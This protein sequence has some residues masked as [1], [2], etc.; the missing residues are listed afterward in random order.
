MRDHVLQNYREQ[1]LLLLRNYVMAEEK[2]LDSYQTILN[3]GTAYMDSMEQNGASVSEIRAGLYPYLDGFYDL[4]SADGLRSYGIVDGQVISNDEEYE[5]FN[6]G[7]YQYADTDWYQ[8]ALAAQGSIYISSAYEDY[9]TGQV[10]VTM[11]QK[12]AHSDSV[13]AFDILFS[14]YRSGDN[15]LD[16]PEEGAY[17]LCDTYGTVMYYQNSAFDDPDE[18][19]AF[20][21][22][23]FA[24]IGDVYTE[25]FQYNYYDSQGVEQGMYTIVLDNGW[26]ILFTVPK[27]NVM[28]GLQSF[29]LS[30]LVVFA[31]GLAL[32]AHLGFRDFRRSRANRRLMDERQSM[33]KTAHI[34]HKAMRSTLLT[35]REV[36]YL[37][38][39]DGTYQ[40]V[41]PEQ[42]DRPMEG[43][44]Q[45]GIARLFDTGILR[46]DNMESVQ[47]FLSPENIRTALGTQECMETRCQHRDR[48]GAWESCVLTLTVAERVDGVPVGATMAIRSIENALRQEEAQRELLTL[49]AQQAEAANHAKSDFLSNMSHDIRTPMNAILGMT[50][51]AAM[52]VNE[53]D[54]V[55]DALNKIT[56]SGKHLLG[57]INSVLDMSK[58]ES[59]KISLNEE[60]FSLADS[61][62]SLLT[63]VHA[64]IEAKQLKLLVKTEVEHERVIGDDQ[65][66][67]QILINIMSNAIKFTP[68]GG[69]IT[70]TVREK[71]SDVTGRGCYEFV[72]EDT[73]IGMSP[74][75]VERIFEPFSRATDSRTSRIEGTGLGMSIAVNVA[76]MMGG[77]IQVESE[78]GKGSCFTVMVY[79]KLDD[80]TPEQLQMLVDLPVLVVDDEQEACENACQVLQSLDMRAEF[81]L[82]GDEAIV[83]VVQAHGDQKDFAVVIL[84][85]KMPGKDG[86]ETAR[87]IRA[88]VGEEVPI[89]ILTA[90]DWS[91]IEQEATLAG[92]NAFIEKPLFKSRLTHVLKQV[93]GI[94]E[95][96]DRAMMP[97]GNDQEAL[98][99][100]RVLVVEDN[101]LNIEVAGEL[102]EMIGVDVEFAYNGQEAV[103]KLQNSSA[104][105]Y[106]LVLMDIQMPIMNG[107]EATEVI[108]ASEREDLR[109]I[110]IIAMTADAFAEDAQRAVDAGMNGHLAK[111]VDIGRLE[112][113]ITQYVK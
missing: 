29:Y 85:W 34:Y 81:A 107:Y 73:G 25:G 59:G 79:L 68:M 91:E 48:D 47:D 44:F 2:E 93:L 112:K 71:H 26:R 92:V 64:Q 35:Y 5:Q 22:E 42:M 54:R 70:L 76:R 18:M 19:Q 31:V 41:Y 13:L 53:P 17:Y 10:C 87:E 111:P 39:E 83:R 27:R 52:H 102:L 40:I 101:D 74:E 69:R 65:R 84:D 45:E 15:A 28:T 56:I 108:R 12:A 75:F 51:I 110:P 106:D 77:D 89:I 60:E 21:D 105:Y 50:A 6:D 30:V 62:D 109:T 14:E 33:T 9:F 49:A 72:F 67:Q 80:V 96:P 58:I 37:D 95:E 78:L 16:L 32:V 97:T 104:G 66:L 113:V 20:A 43:R 7:V 11:A 8:G 88:Q 94:G 46:S 36:C 4:Y 38:L 3:M 82:S 99:G 1:N 61:V 23:A 63:L 55:M 57:L 90:Y 86:V 100:H 24:Q 103:E 98:A